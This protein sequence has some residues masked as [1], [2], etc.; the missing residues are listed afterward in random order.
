MRGDARRPPDD[1]LP[2]RSTLAERELR[3]MLLAVRGCRIIQ[4]T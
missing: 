1:R 3:S 2:G 4:S